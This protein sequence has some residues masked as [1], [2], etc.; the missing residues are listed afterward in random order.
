MG[1]SFLT[2]D[3][4]WEKYLEKAETVY[5]EMEETVELKLR[6]LAE[7]ARTLMDDDGKKWVDDPW[8]SQL[9]WTPK[10]ARESRGIIP[11]TSDEVS[12]GLTLSTQTH[13][14]LV[15]SSGARRC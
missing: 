7:D 9:D 2:V 3:Q 5:R 15:Y 11:I 10:A 12:F 14:V 4:S 6:K 1:S 8:L 13:L